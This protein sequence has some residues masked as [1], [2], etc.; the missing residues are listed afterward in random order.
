V[1]PWRA[2]AK[3]GGLFPGGRS[4]RRIG[5]LRCQ[6]WDEQPLSCAGSVTVLHHHVGASEAPRR[7]H[8]RRH[9]SHIRVGQH[10][11][12]RAGPVSLAA[13]ETRA[14]EII[15]RY[16]QPR[17][18]VLPLLWLVQENFG[19]ISSEAEFWVGRLV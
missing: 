8:D 15:R 14:W 4:E 1:R 2:A 16:D 3:G 12:R 13:L 11:R 5:F 18:A 19:H 9:H 7:G 17:A 10:D 6:R